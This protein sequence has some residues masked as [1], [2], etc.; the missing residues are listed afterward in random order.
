MP[1]K[2]IEKKYGRDPRRDARYHIR[3]Q[4][5]SLHFELICTYLE[6]G[7]KWFLQSETLGLKSIM[8]G[9]SPEMNYED[10]GFAAIKYIKKVLD[11]KLTALALA[12]ECLTEQLTKH[13][14]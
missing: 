7:Y 13:I 1:W 10:A 12:E 5:T 6:D 4:A 14:V 2:I 3:Y 8:L 11:G 9:V